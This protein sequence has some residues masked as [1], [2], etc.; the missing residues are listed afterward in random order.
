LLYGPAGI[1][2]SALLDELRCHREREK[3]SIVFSPGTLEPARW[4]RHV[5]LALASQN[6]DSSAADARAVRARKSAG[7]L[8]SALFEALADGNYALVVDPLGFLSRPFYELLRDLERSAGTPL[9][10]VAR[11][12]H[13]EDMGHAARF[14]WPREQRLALGPLPAGDAERLFDLVLAEWPR[15]PSNAESFR[16][17]VLDYAAGNPGTLLG[18]LAL[19]RQPTYWAEDTLKTHVLTVDFNV[20]GYSPELDKQP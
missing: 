1:G 2:K 3:P 20:R 9:L 10:L 11:S 17:H 4:L 8:R 7:A 6:R 15:R 12:P 5:V 14:A 18:L 19:A 16:A 13:M